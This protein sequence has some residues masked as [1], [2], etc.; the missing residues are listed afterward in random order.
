MKGERVN[1]LKVDGLTS[2]G[3]QGLV[4]PGFLQATGGIHSTS[5]APQGYL[6]GEMGPTNNLGGPHPAP[7]GETWSTNHIYNLNG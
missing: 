6:W 2:Y 7:T 3:S 1:L 4:G 5:Q